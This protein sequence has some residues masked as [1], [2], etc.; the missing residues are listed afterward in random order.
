MLQWLFYLLVV[1]A[2]LSAAAWLAEHALRILHWRT[3]WV[4]VGAMIVIV[5]MGY[6]SIGTAI[7]LP[8]RPLP[9]SS[10]LVQIQH[11]PL[12]L[13]ELL[14]LRSTATAYAAAQRWNSL[15]IAAGIIS[16]FVVLIVL[17]LSAVQIFWRRRRWSLQLLNSVCVGVTPSLGPAVVGL[18]RPTIVIP[19]WVLDRSSSEQEL[20]I[21]HEQ[22]HLDALDPLLLTSAL[23]V[24]VLMPWNLVLWWQLHRL[25]HAIEIDCDARV[26]RAGHDTRAYGE[27]LIEVGQRRGGFL[28]SVAAMSESRTL[29]EKRIEIMTRRSRGPGIYAFAGSLLLA[30]A[31]AIGATQ[32]AAP[33]GTAA[34]QEIS[35]DAATLDQYVGQYKLQGGLYSILTVT[36]DGTQL[37]SQ[38]TGQP[39]LPIFAETPTKFFWKIVDAQV[40]FNVESGSTVATG[41]T[42]RQGGKDISAVRIDSQAAQALEQQLA[43]RISQNKPQAGSEA[44]LRKTIA[45]TQAGTPNYDDLAPALQDATRR[46]LPALQP[47]LKARG[48]IQSVEFKGVAKGGGDQYVVTF[49]NGTQLQSVIALTNDGKIEGLILLPRY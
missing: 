31:L 25:R 18:L 9:S 12:R 4:W 1:S 30:L 16:S 32:I 47:D 24:I 8:H 23:A 17:L 49:Q 20:I 3:R 22:S 5:V 46:Q 41:A 45:A 34:R 11:A 44:A 29:L 27:A 15:L 43:D 19:Q 7:A 10:I 21:A 2:V 38:I 40:T 28:G 13:P 42:I 39:A 35:V 37:S 36:R 6:L 48:P 14:P 33:Q 26:L